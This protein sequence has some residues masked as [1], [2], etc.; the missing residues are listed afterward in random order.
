MIHQR[1]VEYSIASA[2]EDGTS[3]CVIMNGKAGALGYSYVKLYYL[4]D[5]WIR[6]EG[7]NK[8]DSDGWRLLT[9][10]NLEPGKYT[11]TGMRGQAENTIALQLHYYDDTGFSQYL[12]Q[13]DEDIDFTV[14]RVSEAMLHVRVYPNVESLNVL[15]RPAVYR[16]E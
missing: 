10:F 5:G 12:Y 9:K 11:F 1:M 16:N 2:R 8:D 3:N 13:F 4:E 14:E 7:K 6:L 15:A